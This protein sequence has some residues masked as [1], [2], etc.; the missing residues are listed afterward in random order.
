V[1]DIER[2][3][4]TRNCNNTMFAVMYTMLSYRH[5]TYAKAI[6]LIP[7]P[8][9]IEQSQAEAETKAECQ[10]QAV[11]FHQSTQSGRSNIKRQLIGPCTKFQT[12]L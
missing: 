4:R 9:L 7:K 1:E 3:K 12:I 2:L 8:Y 10:A 11:F 6:E 5:M